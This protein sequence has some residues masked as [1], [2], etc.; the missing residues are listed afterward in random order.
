MNFLD[1][2][3]SRSTVVTASTEGVENI[4]ICLRKYARMPFDSS[5]RGNVGCARGEI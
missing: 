2:S 1:L 4:I 3:E 5:V